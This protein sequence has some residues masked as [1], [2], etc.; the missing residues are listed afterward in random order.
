MPAD[1]SA[2]RDKFAEHLAIEVI[3]VR[4]GYAKVRL[5][6]RPHHLNG[7]EMAHGGLIFSLS[8]YAFALAANAGEDSGLAISSNIHFIKAARLDDELYAEAELVSRSRRLGT[9]RM[10]VVDKDGVL[11]ATSQSMAYF[12][13]GPAA[14]DVH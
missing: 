11:M 6:V 8:D 10:N 12:K 4:E 1:N 3:S 7:A 2:L 13:Q 14:R 5:K 9:Y